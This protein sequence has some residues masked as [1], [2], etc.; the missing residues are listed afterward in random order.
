LNIKVFYDNTGFRVRNW[1]KVRSVVQKVITDAEKITDDLNFI[2]T[3]D[4]TL[5]E[6]N[7]KFLKHD[8]LTDVITFNY[9]EKDYIKGEVYLSI[10]TIRRNAINYKDSLNKE[11][12]R[13]IFHGTLHLCG[14]DDKDE[15]Q[16]KEMR[17]ME[18]KYLG[19]LNEL[20]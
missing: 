19:V 2:I 6:I 3:T 11:L 16:K 13:V 20:E 7:K 12:N 10:D 17:L 18:E 9:N 15:L 14:Y 4:E 5:L 1:K 8:W